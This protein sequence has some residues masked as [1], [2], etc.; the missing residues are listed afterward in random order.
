MTVTFFSNFPI[1]SLQSNFALGLLF[2]DVIPS[3]GLMACK[4]A[5]E[6]Y[7]A[8]CNKRVVGFCGAVYRIIAL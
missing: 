1:K 6:Y 4:V 5:L 3:S 2:D 7:Y 8:A